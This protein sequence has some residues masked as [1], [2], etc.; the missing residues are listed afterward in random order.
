MAESATTRALPRFDAW[1]GGRKVAPASGEYFETM[2]PYTSR[3]WAEVEV[4]QTV[5]R[6]DDDRA[7]LARDCLELLRRLG[8]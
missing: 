4:T 2:N 1:I 6:S 8:T 3:A 7:S 5:M